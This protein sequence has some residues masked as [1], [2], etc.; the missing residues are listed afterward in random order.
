MTTH[1]PIFARDGGGERLAMHGNPKYMWD[2]KDYKAIKRLLERLGFV[3]VAGWVRK[4]DAPAI[5]RK[6]EKT[7]PQVEALREWNETE[8]GGKTDE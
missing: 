5:R 7:R 6:I 2:M 4:E 8:P 1:A 3:H